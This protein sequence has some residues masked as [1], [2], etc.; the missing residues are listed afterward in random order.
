LLFVFLVVNFFPDVS[1]KPSKP[2]GDN[3]S[4]AGTHEPARDAAA[5]M[6]FQSFFCGSAEKTRFDRG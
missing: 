2:S 3:T 4:F 1:I 5:T 6:D